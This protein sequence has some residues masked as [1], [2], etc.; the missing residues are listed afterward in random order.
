MRV[1]LLAIA[2]GAIG[3]AVLGPFASAQN[4]NDPFLR[5]IENLKRSIAPVVCVA[6]G[7]E[8][9]VTVD[10]TAF[11]VSE[12]GTF[13]T[14]GHVVQDFLPG[15][16][17]A[18]CPRPAIYFQI[19]QSRGGGLDLAWFQFQPDACTIDE[20]LDLAKCKTLEN[21]AAAQGGRFKPLPAAVETGIVQDGTPIA[22]TGYPLSV[23]APLTSRGS[24][25]GYFLDG[26]P[27]L[28]VDRNVWPGASGSPIYLVNGRVIGIVTARGIADAAGLTFAR[29]GAAMEAFL[30][31]HP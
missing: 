6:D 12:A 24:V 4:Q 29:S 31:A 21:L 18:Q 23:I 8:R 25:A 13:L 16:A 3:T 30:R 28:V 22:F 9:P 11:F 14:A 26:P 7:T 15:H 5:T 2:F 19:G 27:T 1:R 17:F 20:K 10:G